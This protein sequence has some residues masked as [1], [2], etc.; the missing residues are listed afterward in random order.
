MLGFGFVCFGVAVVVCLFV[1]FVCCCCCVFFGGL[2]VGV[3]W[4]FVFFW[5][6][7][8]MLIKALLNNCI[9]F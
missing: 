2:C 6:E 1:G 3:I 8:F 9:Y 4:F 7:G 5:G